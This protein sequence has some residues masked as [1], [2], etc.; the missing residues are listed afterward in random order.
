MLPERIQRKHLKSECSKFKIHIV[1]YF[2]RSQK[3][4]I[5]NYH[6]HWFTIRKIGSQW[7]NLNSLHSAPELISDTYLLLFLTQLQQEGYSIFIVNGILPDCRADQVLAARTVSPVPKPYLSAAKTEAVQ[8]V[9]ELTKGQDGFT[10]EEREQFRRTIEMSVNSHE[11]EE[12][13][14]LE[15]VLAMSLSPSD[16]PVGQSEATCS[17]LTEDEM[18]DAALKMSLEAS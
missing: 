15:A 9:E 17:F 10:D 8:M 7:F 12:R 6:E 3:A 18:L 4:Y 1:I 13:R 5:C 11:E 16:Q 2:T 14:Q